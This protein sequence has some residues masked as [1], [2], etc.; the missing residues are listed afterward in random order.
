MVL[1][2]GADP[3]RADLSA[4]SVRGMR[5]TCSGGYDLTGMRVGDEALIGGPLDYL[6]EPRFS[7]GAWRFTAV[8]LGGVERVLTLLRDHLATGAE[9]DPVR[10]A[11]S[12]YLWVREA[13]ERA[14]APDA[15]PEAIAFVLMTRGVVERAGLAVIEAAQR[16]IGTKAFF[17][18]HPIDQAC[19]DLALYLRQPVPDQALDR[20]AKAFIAKDCW[21]GDAL[22]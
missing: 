16:T 21:E 11:R 12:A 20:A 14:Q 10:A 9:V 22:W 1:V 15:G 19:R 13:A 4:W 2:D 17:V 5:A 8:Q 6:K 18:E 3:E 7:A